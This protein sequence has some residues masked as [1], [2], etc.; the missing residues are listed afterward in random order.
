MKGKHQDLLCRGQVEEPAPGGHD[1][2]GGKVD[3]R[4]PVRL[5][6]MDL[7]EHRIGNVQQLLAVRSNGN[8]HAPRKIKKEKQGVS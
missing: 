5:L 8:R 3:G 6:Q 4:I 2:L 7:M 1:L